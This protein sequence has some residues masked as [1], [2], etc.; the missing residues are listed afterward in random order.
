MRWLLPVFLLASCSGPTTAPDPDPVADARPRLDGVPVF[1]VSIEEAPADAQEVWRVSERLLED[2]GPEPPPDLGLEDYMTWMRGIWSPWLEGRVAIMRDLRDRFSAL[3]E[4]GPRERVFSSVVAGYLYEDFARLIENLPVP[5]EVQDDREMSAAFASQLRAQAA[6]AWA[7]A[8]EAW[9]HCIDWAPDAPESLRGWGDACTR[10]LAELPVI[11]PEPS[12]PPAIAW[13][14]ECTTGPEGERPDA[15]D[16]GPTGRRPIAL[17][18]SRRGPLTEAE[19]DRVA[20]AVHRHVRR[21]YRN[22]RLL[23]LREV[24]QARSTAA[25]G[26]R[27]RR[28]SCVRAPSP[29]SLLRARHED[30]VVGSVSADCFLLDDE[31]VCELR[32]YLGK[33]DD[34]SVLSI[35]AR[36][37]EI[38]YDVDDWLAL[39]P[40]LSEE[41]ASSLVFG[42]TGA[43]RVAGAVQVRSV[44]TYGEWGDVDV[45]AV[46]QAAENGLAQCRDAGTMPPADMSVVLEIAPDGAVS[47][48]AIA[49]GPHGVPRADCVNN[50][51]EDLTVPTASGERRVTFSLA[52]YP[53]AP[54]PL[55]YRA[56]ERVPHGLA[57]GFESA[58]RDRFLRDA[59]ARCYAGLPE[60]RQSV[61]SY[62]ATLA[63]QPNGEVGDVTVAG[64]TVPDGVGEAVSE[65]VATAL[66]GARFSCPMDRQPTTV[67]A[68]LC[69]GGR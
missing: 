42:S 39:V 55:P 54:V 13:P 1:D 67:E 24:R 17:S 19:R 9:S 41:G 6:P 36:L 34:G 16:A 10:R 49:T 38:S 56:I 46:L 57:L 25:A 45:A 8:R 48:V 58:L 50:V 30:L 4:V 65:C 11:E 66:R 51:F 31:R 59:V 64:V 3:A 28:L 7:R 60:S 68:T 14:E 43:G 47:D 23:P 35:G 33:K 52:F 69:I 12:A 53:D 27:T 20:D 22:L 61:A 44:E 5:V 62:S 2:R 29:T 63:V 37:E 15:I 21:T 32:V 26:N 18:T 40:S